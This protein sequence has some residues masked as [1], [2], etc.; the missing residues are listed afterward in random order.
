MQQA[1]SELESPLPSGPNGWIWV[2]CVVFCLLSMTLGWGLGELWGNEGLRARVAAEMA[3]HNPAGNK[4]WWVPRLEGEPLLTKPPLQYWMVAGLG[5]LTGRVGVFESRFPSV[6][7]G[8]VIAGLAAWQAWRKIG[9]V[10]AW[11]ALLVVPASLAMLTQAPSAELDLPLCAWVFGGL[12]G[13]DLVFGGEKGWEN[14]GWCVLGICLLGGFLQKWTGPAYLLPVLAGLLVWFKRWKTLLNPVVWCVAG[15]A[16]ILAGGWVY[17]AAREVG[18]ETFWQTVVRRE[19]LEHLSPA[20][21]G[22]AYPFHE[23]LTYPLQVLA[24]GLPGA[25]WLGTWWLLTPRGKKQLL[26][27]NWVIV[28]GFAVVIPLVFWTLVPGHKP[29]HALGVIAPISALAGLV[30][31]RCLL[32]RQGAVGKV[33]WRVLTVGALLWLGM[34]GGQMAMK[35]HEADSAMAPTRV[36]NQISG[37]LESSYGRPLG[38]GLLR[39]DGLFLALAH[40]G[41]SVVRNRDV[42]E[43]GEIEFWLITGQEKELFGSNADVVLETVDQQGKPVW[44]VRMVGTR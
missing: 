25:F 10:G 3:A 5:R 41:F 19:G 15:L 30:L 21:H 40:R 39:D 11:C 26:H 37:A 28:L 24:M 13:L 34:K 17:V 33:L 22:R 32:D 35:G 4:S 2:L 12:V 27:D 16:M 6:L 43:S 7:A 29:R 8:L 20:H 31:A 38:I 18:F 23:W 14:L 42:G 36:A 1:C 44:L 9:P